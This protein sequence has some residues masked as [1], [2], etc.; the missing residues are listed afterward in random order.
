MFR[1]FIELFIR[2]RHFWRYATFSE[3][4]EIYISRILRVVGI[5]LASG[6]AT[7][8]LYQQ[9]FSMVELAMMWGVYYLLKML[10]IPT[11]S[12][13]Y[14]AYFG[15]KHGIFLSNVLYI[16]AMAGLALVPETPTVGLSLWYIFLAAST[17]LYGLS[18]NVNF[19]KVKNFAHAGKEMGFVNIFDKLSAGVS[20]LIGGTL[21]FLMGPQMVMWIGAALFLVSAV[22]LFNSREQTRLRQKLN[23]SGFPWRM[24]WRSLISRTAIGFDYGVTATVW[25]MFILVAIFPTFGN[26]IYVLFGSFAF[27]TVV[28]AVVSSYAYGKLIDSSKGGDLLKVSV[29]LNSLVHVSRSFIGT[30]AGI[31]TTNIANEISTSGVQLAY[32]RG[33]FDTADLS[34]NR[35]IYLCV[36][37]M[38][39]DLGGALS[40]AV[41]LPLLLMLGDVDGLK[42]MFAVT[43]IY[44][45]LALA[46]KFQLYRR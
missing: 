21:A 24:A 11:L 12:A 15:P 14:V 46:A 20:P 36:S 4:A 9:G 5:N 17:T 6:F 26:E 2:R 34:G 39:Y 1:K 22:P 25:T 19:S 23:L 42:A 18:Y 40:F 44:T 37:D 27:V 30:P 7:V 43:A 29:V 45:L 38:F 3:V 16:P 33:V 8:Y 41:L 28:A 35:I 31:I 32:M 13:P 10:F